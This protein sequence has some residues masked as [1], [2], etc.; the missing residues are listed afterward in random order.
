MFKNEREKELIEE[1]RKYI[2]DKRG[3]FNQYRSFLPVYKK[4]K[5]A[6]KKTLNSSVT[7]DLVDVPSYRAMQETQVKVIMDNIKNERKVLDIHPENRLFKI[8]DCFMYSIRFIEKDLKLLLSENYF[9]EIKRIKIDD[10]QVYKNLKE[11]LRIKKSI[12][13]EH[14]KFLLAFYKMIPS[15]LSEE[16][17]KREGK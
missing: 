3:L 7:Q 15:L 4:A 16:R 1:V 13:D 9:K 6:L 17:K 12:I 14:F 5:K 2:T 11:I 10:D 8:N